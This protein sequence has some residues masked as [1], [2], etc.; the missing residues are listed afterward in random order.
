MKKIILVISLLAA[1]TLSYF[2]WAKIQLVQSDSSNLLV[3]V[4]QNTQQII[5]VKQVN[6][7]LIKLE[8]NLSFY[9]EIKKNKDLKSTSNLLNRL[10]SG[11]ELPE[12]FSLTFSSVRNGN[13]LDW[14]LISKLFE[15]KNGVVP[16][17]KKYQEE[18][19]FEVD[20][21]EGR[22]FYYIHQDVMYISTS[23]VGLQ[24]CI[25]EVSS[26]DFFRYEENKVLFQSL[27]GSDFSFASKQE[28]DS[29]KEYDF[30]VKRDRI[31]LMSSQ[32]KQ[33]DVVLRLLEK[34]PK[35]V[36]FESSTISVDSNSSVLSGELLEIYNSNSTLHLLGLN[37]SLKYSH[38]SDRFDYDSVDDNRFSLQSDAFYEL[39]KNDFKSNII[40]TVYGIEDVDYALFSTS[41]SELNSFYFKL[42]KNEN[43]TKQKSSEYGALSYFSRNKF[44]ESENILVEKSVFIE[45]EVENLEKIVVRQK[46]KIEEE[47]QR[48]T[49]STEFDSNISQLYKIRNHRTGTNEVIVQI[50]NNNVSLIDVNGK[51][52]WTIPLGER[53]IGGISQVDLFKNGKL[54]MLF[55]TAH[56]IHLI[57]IL[58]R[59]VE[60][61]PVKL[62]SSA[63]NQVSALDYENTKDYRFVVA[64]HKG[65]SNYNTQGKK[66]KG[67]QFNRSNLDV[68][69][70]IKH[71][72]I[73]SK[74]YIMFSDK[75]GKIY[76]L[77]RR[78]QERYYSALNLS[79]GN[80][81]E[82]FK[83]SSSISSSFTFGLN[84]NKNL[85][86]FIL[87]PN[88]KVNVKDSTVLNSIHKSNS[89]KNYMLGLTDRSVLIYTK[90]GSLIRE[91]MCDFEPKSIVSKMKSAQDG[92]LLISSKSNELY[93]FDLY[94]NEVVEAF[95]GAWLSPILEDFDKDSNLEFVLIQEGN[96]LINYPIK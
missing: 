81:L 49:W 41:R 34:L 65:V 72:S 14:L 24:D 27:S 68:S 90:T 59:N 42:K 31:E 26:N 57:D 38:F 12:N 83:A 55:N 94:K 75:T 82:F 35:N 33:E 61:F 22:F 66:V 36:L 43:I 56:Q 58:G 60:G 54:Q 76:F 95:Q 93:L 7:L 16:N 91:I 48:Y 80:T 8:E 70:K 50:E 30:F 86:E 5:E 21:A 87:S 40:D 89:T 77:D 52:K 62:N 78:G 13:D 67:F 23:M 39:I 6:K 88:G 28:D 45:N 2:L 64:T 51:I 63:T 29:W 53:I 74:D 20:L 79:E 46:G 96:K 18:E 85:S 9:D 10:K 15:L 3:Y 32:R 71:V 44:N 1:A 4:P 11:F 25:N 19:Y 17:L 73:A 47:S 37:K 92:I 84:S 69:E